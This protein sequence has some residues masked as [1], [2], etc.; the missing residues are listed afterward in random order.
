[1]PTD[2]RENVSSAP[3]GSLRKGPASAGR[4]VPGVAPDV[5]KNRTTSEIRKYPCGVSARESQVIELAHLSN[6]EIAEK[7]G[8]SYETVKVHMKNA[9]VKLGAENRTSAAMLLARAA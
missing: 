1:M 4:C 3:T 9:F 5:N 7:L 6:A 2:E 8:I